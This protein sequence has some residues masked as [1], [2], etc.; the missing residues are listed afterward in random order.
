MFQSQGKVRVGSNPDGRRY[1]QNIVDSHDLKHI[2]ARKTHLCY[3]IT[4]NADKHNDT[5]DTVK[6]H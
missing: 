4:I 2:Y 6:Q 3:F 5:I 1:F